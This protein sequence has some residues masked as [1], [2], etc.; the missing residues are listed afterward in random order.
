MANRLK[1]RTACSHPPHPSHP[2]GRPT[3]KQTTIVIINSVS[4]INILTGGPKLS[5]DICDTCID[6][7]SLSIPIQGS[8]ARAPL[9]AT[10][11]AIDRLQFK[12]SYS[13]GHF[14][15]INQAPTRHP[16]DVANVLPFAVGRSPLVDVDK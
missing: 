13:F 15:G 6:L 7:S 5:S 10:C 11:P 2:W 3:D 14:T 16:L 12:F 9:K 4:D 1:R 8:S